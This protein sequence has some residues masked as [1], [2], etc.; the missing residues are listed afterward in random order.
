MRISVYKHICKIPHCPA[1][2]RRDPDAGSPHRITWFNDFHGSSVNSRFMPVSTEPVFFYVCGKRYIF[3]GDT[4][5]NKTIMRRTSHRTDA[6]DLFLFNVKTFFGA[7][8][9]PPGHPPG[10]ITA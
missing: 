2:P 5:Q 10:T 3:A 6:K 8:P 1:V 4:G 7:L 9:P